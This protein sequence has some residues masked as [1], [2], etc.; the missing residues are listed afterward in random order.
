MNHVYLI[1][2]VVLK[3]P[4]FQSQKYGRPMPNY[5]ISNVLAVSDRD[6]GG[7]LPLR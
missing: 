2:V 5:K 6:K 1:R 3:R 7:C 4:G